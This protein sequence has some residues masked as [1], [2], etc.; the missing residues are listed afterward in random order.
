[1]LQFFKTTY[2]EFEKYL[3][4][5]QKGADEEDIHQLRVAL[6]KLKTILHIVD[7]ENKIL[8][9]SER[10]LIRR[11][12]KLAG[13]IREVQVNIALVQHI[14]DKPIEM[15]R[16]FLAEQITYGAKALQRFTSD[17]KTTDFFS[18]NTVKKISKKTKHFTKS[19][20]LDALRIKVYRRIERYI[21]Y[22]GDKILHE[23]RKEIKH[24]LFIT[25]FDPKANNNKGLLD[26]LADTLGTWHDQA[27][28][29]YSLESFSVKDPRIF[30]HL[31]SIKYWNRIRAVQ[32]RAEV[33]SFLGGIQ[34]AL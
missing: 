32:M 1:M 15:Y 12:F 9:S 7:P 6:K 26:S 13:I 21:H 18:R 29:L 10:K 31:E 28:L 34:P 19:K 17:K 3:K 27:V 22:T 8:K 16:S 2:K 5:V 20:Q 4:R 14:D 25:K 33:K 24:L 23:V 30:R 11:L